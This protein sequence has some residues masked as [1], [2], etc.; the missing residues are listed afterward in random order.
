MENGKSGV[1]LP[2]GATFFLGRGGYQSIGRGEKGA[3][4]PAAAPARR[5]PP[6]ADRSNKFTPCRP[7]D[8]RE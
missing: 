5:P 4:P 6:A 1:W 8:R 3:P 2:E 7:T